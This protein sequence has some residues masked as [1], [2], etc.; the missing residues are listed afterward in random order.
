MPISASIGLLGSIAEVQQ[1]TNI[2]NNQRYEANFIL[3]GCY[4]APA[5]YEQYK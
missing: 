4:T 2:P 3:H 5:T 1:I